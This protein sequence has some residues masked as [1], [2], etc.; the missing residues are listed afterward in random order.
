MLW[1]LLAVAALVA[2]TADAGCTQNVLINPTLWNF[3]CTLIDGTH[4]P[5]SRFFGRVVLVENT[6]SM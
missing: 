3:T 1:R 4:Q 2:Q 5:L 6:A